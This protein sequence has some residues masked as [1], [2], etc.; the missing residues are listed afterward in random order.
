VRFFLAGVAETAAKGRDVFRDILAL[1]TDVEQTL[2]G[3]GKRAPLARQALNVLYRTPIV[4][5]A[6]LEK[7]LQISTPTANALIRELIRGGVLVEMTGQQRGRVYV[8]D[9]YFNL[10]VS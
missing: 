1:R 3:L 4:S 5:A 10:F 7:G 6:D 8:F 9:R 2:L